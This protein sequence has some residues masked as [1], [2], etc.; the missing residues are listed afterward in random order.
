MSRADAVL[1]KEDLSVVADAI[2]LA[3]QTRRVMYQNLTWSVLYNALSLPL[4]AVGWVTPYWAA[5]GMSLS[6]VVVVLNAV[7]LGRPPQAP[8]V[9]PPEAI[10]EAPKA[11]ALDG[12]CA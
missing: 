9:R 12:A 7:R 6:S 10:S 4:A 1:L 2:E 5:L 11:L 8:A 3:R